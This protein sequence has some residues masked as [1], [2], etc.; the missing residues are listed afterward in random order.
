M[1]T[2]H[3][4]AP[5]QIVHLD[6]DTF[7]VSVERILDPTLERKPVIVGGAPNERGVVAGCSYEARSFGVHSAMPLRQAYRLCP[8]GVFLR[9]SYPYYGEYSRLV[10]EILQDI[11]PMVEKGSIDEFY[12]DLSHT[13]RLKGNTYTWARSIQDTIK[14]ETH[15]PI[16]FGLAVNK[17]VAKVATSQVAKVNRERSFNVM[18]GSEEA[19]LAPMSVHALPG[20]GEKTSQDLIE[21]GIHTVGQLAQTPVR[22]LRSLYGKTGVT[23]SEH[24]HGIDLRPVVPTRVRKSISRERTFDVDTYEAPYIVATLRALVAD[25]CEDLRSEGRIAGKIGLK[26]RYSD[27]KTV[28]TTRTVSYTNNDNEVFGLGE[29]LLRALWTRRNKIRLIGIESSDLIE[30]YSMGFLFPDQ[31]SDAKLFSAVD[32]LRTKY[33]SAVIGIGAEFVARGKVI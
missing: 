4:A 10:T 31:R 19:F 20:V 22:L 30:D 12:L 9:G 8:D 1:S 18:P 14:G 17:L 16:S 5:P 33:G 28:T 25:L 15:L 24:A 13:E 11:S 27:F 6:L 2:C 29:K 23:L 26:L 21:Y 3:T 32:A 7:F